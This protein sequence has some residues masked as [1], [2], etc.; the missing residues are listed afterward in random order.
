MFLRATH[1]SSPRLGGRSNIEVRSLVANATLA[2]PMSCC[3]LLDDHRLLARR[4][5]VIFTGRNVISSIVTNPVPKTVFQGNGLYAIWMLVARDACI[6]F[7]LTKG[8]MPSRKVR[9]D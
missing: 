1:A 2:K 6:T 8:T 7:G 5:E 4:T 3:V 9:V